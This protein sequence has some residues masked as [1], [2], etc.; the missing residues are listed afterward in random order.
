MDK[1]RFAKKS[2][3][4]KYTGQLTKTTLACVDGLLEASDM[5]DAVALVSEHEVLRRVQERMAAS[6]RAKA[7][8]RKM[9]TL[10]ADDYTDVEARLFLPAVVGCSLQNDTVLHRRWKVTCPTPPDDPGVY[11]RVWSEPRASVAALRE[12]L[13]WCWARHEEACGEQC[14]YD[15]S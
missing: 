12:V 1:H 7:K 2:T 3:M 11:S 6:A 5:Q 8:P 9:R 14:A 13:A 4:R 15:L 10:A